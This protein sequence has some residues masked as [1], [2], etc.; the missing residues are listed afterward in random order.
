LEVRQVDDFVIATLSINDE[1]RIGEQTASG[2][3][4]SLCVFSQSAARWQWAA[5]QTMTVGAG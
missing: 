1:L 2:R 4:K 5:G 3:Y